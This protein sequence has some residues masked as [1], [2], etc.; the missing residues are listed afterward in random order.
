MA[1]TFFGITDTGKVRDNNEDAFIAQKAMNGQYIIA[2]AIDGVGGYSGGEVAAA[3]AKE[4]ILNYFTVLSGDMTSMMKEGF[5][6]ANEKI[7]TE[8]QKNAEYVNMACVLTLAIVD[9]AN[10]QFY[11]AHVGDTRL[12]LFRDKSLVKL[13]KDQSFVGF[14]EDSGRLTEQE[15]MDH[16]KRNEINK[17][18]GFGEQTAL[19]DDY[20]ETGQSPFLPGDLL[21]LCS[22]GLT[23]LVNKEEITSVLTEKISLK[24]KATLLVSSANSKGGKD[25]ITVVLVKNEKK[26][27]KQKATKPTIIVKKNIRQKEQIELVEQPASGVVERISVAKQKSRHGFITFLSIL[28]IGLGAAILWM[29]WL[30][31][32]GVTSSNE[33]DAASKE[34]TKTFLEIKLQN[35]IDAMA[36]DTLILS[37]TAFAEPIILTRT[38]FIEK[39][40]LYIKAEGNIVLKSDWGFAGPAISILPQSQH[41]VLD[42]LIFNGFEIA[43]ATH[44]KVL[45]LNKVRFINCATPVQTS[46]NF[47]NDVFVSGTIKDTSFKTDSLPNTSN[48]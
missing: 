11:Y 22:D 48:N 15:A 36:G 38:L 23:D 30:K 26:P 13:S 2:C 3:I 10:N 25:N 5:I 9:V 1:D 46:F 27:L 7:F 8:K 37:D 14:L 19:T 43:V 41:I 16:P 24:Q 6:H 12:Y 21:L 32:N 17:A 33:S 39:D 35:A 42:S 29:L 4:S 20:I 28:C 18:L 31:Y 34:R 44:D 40:S 45:R 47:S